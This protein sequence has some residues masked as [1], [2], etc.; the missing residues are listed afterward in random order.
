MDALLN[1]RYWLLIIAI[2]L[3]GT[4]ANLATYYLGREGSSAVFERYPTLEAS[5][6]WQRVNDWFQR[7]GSRTLVLSFIP[8]L[9][10]A[11]SAAA[12]IFKIRMTIF[13]L[14][15]F[16]AKVIRNWVILLLALSLLRISRAI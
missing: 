15:V 13:L 1:L 14:A 16:A 7:W 11:L 12:G 4:S 10:T 6:S 5:S 3:V 2:S 8:V 9:V